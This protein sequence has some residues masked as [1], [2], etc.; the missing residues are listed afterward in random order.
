VHPALPRALPFI[1]YIA[2]LA[3][4]SAVGQVAESAVY[5]V[6]LIY[7]CKIACVA[8]LLVFFWRS[9]VDLARFGLQLPQILWSVVTGV[10]VFLLWI[11]LDQAWMS[12]GHSAGFDPRKLSGA[13]DWSLALPRLLGAA[14]VVPVMEELFWRSFVMRWIDQPDFLNLSPADIGLRALLLS[15]VL[16]GLEH[17]LWLAGVMAGL[18][19][20]WLYMKSRNLWAAVLAHSTTNGLLGLWV[21]QTGNW[22]FW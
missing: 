12:F 11:S 22:S 14:L 1:I 15:S 8:F 7:P 21:L 4:A 10:A 5:D 20:G 2:F 16:F 19:Y 6:R 18:A 9:Y 17:T 13:I 3:L